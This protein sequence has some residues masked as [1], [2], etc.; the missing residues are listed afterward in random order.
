MASF[1]FQ[2][3]IHAQE[4]IE[5][6]WRIE[7]L[8]SIDVLIP[9]NSGRILNLTGLGRAEEAEILASRYLADYRT[10]GFVPPQLLHP[11]TTEIIQA[12]LD[13]T[14]GNPR[15]F[16]RTLGN[17]ID[18]ARDDERESLDLTYVEPLLDIDY[19]AQAE[20]VE[21]EFENPVR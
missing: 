13:A 6:W 10:D 11:F 3:H 4:A 20:D 12:V 7:D 5:S 9:T 15:D 18:K 19:E 1:I 2:M 21:D 8:P 16:L 14:S 17:I